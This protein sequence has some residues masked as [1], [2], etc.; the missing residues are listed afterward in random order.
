MTIDEIRREERAKAY[1][2][3]AIAIDQLVALYESGVPAL[4]GHPINDEA[5]V[6]VPL[7]KGLKTAIERQAQAPA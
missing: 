7:L 3:V 6:A 5:K 2:E 4:S 1:A